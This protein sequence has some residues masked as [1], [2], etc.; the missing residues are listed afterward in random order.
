MDW[1]GLLVCITVKQITMSLA[2]ANNAHLLSRNFCRLG[3]W[4]LL[5][6]VLCSEPLPTAVGAWGVL[7]SHLETQGGLNALPCPSRVWAEFI[8]LQSVT[9]K[10]GFSLAVSWR[11]PSGQTSRGSC[12]MA[13]SRAGS[14]HGC[15]LLQGWQERLSRMP[16]LHPA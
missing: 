6:R 9:E 7:C 4:A 15:L 8:C 11:P 10:P 5:N 12:P 3:I 1:A 16:R 14:Q 2:V 13:L